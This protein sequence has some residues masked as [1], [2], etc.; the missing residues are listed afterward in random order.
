VIECK[1]R[2]TG[3]GPAAR[4]ALADLLAYRRGFNTTLAEAGTPRG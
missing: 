1:L 3:V 2:S 4:D